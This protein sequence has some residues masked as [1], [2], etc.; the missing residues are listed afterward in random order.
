MKELK[1]KNSFTL[2]FSLFLQEKFIYKSLTKISSKMSP[3]KTTSFVS[4]K[5]VPL[6]IGLISWSNELHDQISYQTFSQ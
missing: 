5:P 3:W 1:I 4:F 2:I 6:L